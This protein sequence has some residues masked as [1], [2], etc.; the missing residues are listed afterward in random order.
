MAEE[1]TIAIHFKADGVADVTGAF[2]RVSTAATKT[3]ATVADFGAKLTGK[4]AQ[5][6]GAFGAALSTAIP[7]IGG[8][9]S[10][11]G[12]A[13]GVIG[14]M[15]ALLGG[16][17][18][19]AIG[20][21]VTAVGLLSA[22]FAKARDDAEE[23][24]KALAQTTG[25][26]SGSARADN[27][28]AAALGRAGFF[29]SVTRS[30]H[31]RETIEDVNAAEARQSSM[32]FDRVGSDAKGA[33]AKRADPFA[34]VQRRA[35]VEK[36]LAD[37]RS[38][39]TQAEMAR[40]RSE[41]DVRIEQTKRRIDLEIQM[42][43]D[44]HAEIISAAKSRD[45]ELAQIDAET[46]KREQQK[47]TVAVG[48]FGAVATSGISALQKLAKGQKTSAKEF[49]ASVGDQIV[50]KGTGHILEGVAL[51]V[52]PGLWASGPPLIA[53]GAAEVAFGIGLG[54]ASRGGGSSSSPGSRSTPYGYASDRAGGG[55]ASPTVRP[56]QSVGN[57]RVR[58][59]NVN[60]PTVVSPTADDGRRVGR[61]IQELE[62]SGG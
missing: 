50:A 31:S 23:L 45:A 53:A 3:G 41:S 35:A 30:A 4:G 34:D 27:A 22:A 43:R 62:R 51:A 21:A 39:E 1:D 9:T 24:N 7:E 17:W 60:M 10:A 58:V 47:R 49:I 5:A 54:A 12:R 52:T 56:G 42:E 20:A 32:I 33:G 16:P 61:A 13:S 28:H 57:E 48:A 37:L 19:L 11:I 59:V 18:G 55:P 2:D 29:D 15:T 26:P 40:A 14:S 46:E 6:V 25:G 44:H 8:F 36:Q 38:Q